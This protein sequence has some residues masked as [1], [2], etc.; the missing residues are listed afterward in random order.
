MIKNKNKI[1]Q[2]IFLFFT[3][4]LILRGL[5]SFAQSDSIFIWIGQSEQ[6]IKSDKLAESLVL[7]QKA[8]DSAQKSGNDDQIGAAARQLAEVHRLRSGFDKAEELLNTATNAYKKHGNNVLYAHSLAELARIKQAQRNFDKAIELYTQ[9][10]TIYNEKLSPEE[11]AKNLNLK[12]FILERMAVISSSHQKLYDQAE[13]YA[14]EAL[15]ICES[16]N[17]QKQLEITCTSMGNIFF[18]RK[19]YQKAK[20]YYER[21][22]QISSS[23]GF[24]TG[25][26][27]NNLG[28]IATNLGD[29]T[30]AVEH[31]MAAI[32]QYKKLNA[33]ELIAQTQINIGDLYNHQGNYPKAIEFSK[34]GIEGLNSIKKVKGLVEGYEILINAYAHSNNYQKAFEFQT[35]Y[36]QLK[37]SL[38][39]Q[40]QL[41][42]LSALQT[43]FETVKKDNEILLLNKQNSAHVRN[44]DLL[45][46]AIFFLILLAGFGWF[47]LR[48]RQ[49]I[50][51]ERE[52][53]AQ[54]RAEEDAKRH[55]QETELRALRS[56]MNP[57]FIFNCLNSIKSL[58]LKNETDKASSY[59]TKFSRLMRLV[60]E[61]SRSEWISLQE[62]LDT[63]SLYLE[64]EKL[65]FQDKF[66]FKIEISP[67]IST[68]SINIPP[69]LI[70]PYVENSIWH[71]LLPKEGN[72]CVR[73]SLSENDDNQLIIKIID[74]GV[75]RKRSAELKSKSATEKKSFGLQIT[76]ERMDILNQYYKI[77]ATSSIKDLYDELGN[78]NGTEVCLTIPI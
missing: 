6:L 34:L 40:N 63:L 72:G 2:V 32:E 67:D 57:H 39:K 64:M 61:N 7:A 5:Q 65:R 15:T 22:Y 3:I 66:E 24:N 62:E 27:L 9:A 42:E 8:F 28:M 51:E 14:Q 26:N 29:P 48:Y 13:T 30:K 47:F 36:I 11:A 71:G 31:Y 33:N 54:L 44:N 68:A 75:G 73:I 10:Q 25:R 76:S 58:T 52:H 19:N 56:Q 46:G 59:I 35:T 12:A 78:P 41:N 17:D 69:M 45:R 60:L 37:D 20:E 70:Q 1:I 50:K 4:A 74:N 38:F 23:L 18:W 43:K 77:N 55:W 53:M 16:I 21:A 49:K